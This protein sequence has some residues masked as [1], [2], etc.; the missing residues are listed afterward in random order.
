MTEKQIVSTA[1][2]AHSDPDKARSEQEHEQWLDHTQDGDE[3]VPVSFA[4]LGSSSSDLRQ[5]MQ[6]WATPWD[7]AMVLA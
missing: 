1:A 2:D 3:D 6:R 4:L 7:E 5:I